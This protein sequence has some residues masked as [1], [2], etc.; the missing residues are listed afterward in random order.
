MSDELR[1][2][3]PDRRQIFLDTVDLESQLPEDHMARIVWDFV[4]TLDISPLERGIK[5]REGHPGR[6]TPD[7]RLYMAL[8]LCA[9][10]DGVGAAREL[11]RQCRMHTAYRW[12]CGGVPVNYHDLADFRVE[13]GEFLDELLSGSVAALVAQGLVGLDC[14][15][16]DSVRV[17]ASAGSNSFRR[18]ESLTRLYEAAQTKVAALRAE[19]E[20]DPGAASKRLQA[21]QVRARSERAAAVSAAK[22]ALETIKAERVK[23]AE[24]QRR[25]TV[26]GN[27]PRA[28]TTDS[29]ARVMKCDGGFRPAYNF[30]IRTDVESGIVLGLAVTNCASD[31]GLLTPA[32]EDIERRYRT[33]PKQVLADSGYDA[34]DDIEHLYSG[35]AGAIDVFCPLPGSKGKPGDPTPKPSDG[36]GVIAWR[37][38]MSSEAGLKFYRKR[39]ATERPH[40]D[41]R[42]RGLTKLVVR[43][44]TKVKAVALWH[45]VRYNFL[46]TRFLRTTA[47]QARPV[48]A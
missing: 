41:M 37:E 42:N 28:S 12:L 45:V 3:R 18:E 20:A 34:K 33:R 39:F 21:R 46:Q 16:V 19:I 32:V 17:R 31:R 40:A 9:T 35:A 2:L 1:V 23:E 8:W 6:P 10:L 26:R 7:R 5:S 44:M 43:G 22:A 24:K 27:P 13:A 14:L 38:R 4:E 30:Q 47:E 25:K 29:Q 15:A 48:A 36:P 11:D